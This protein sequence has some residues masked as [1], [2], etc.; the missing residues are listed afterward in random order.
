MELIV[1]GLLTISILICILSIIFCIL[2]IIKF[3]PV[4]DIPGPRG[5]DGDK[6]PEG[7]RGDKGPQGQQGPYGPSFENPNITP[8]DRT[9]ESSGPT[10][11]EYWIKGYG[12]YTELWSRAMLKWDPS[13]D[14]LPLYIICT[15]VVSDSPLLDIVEGIENYEGIVVQLLYTNDSQ[16]KRYSILENRLPRWSS[17]QIY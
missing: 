16:R 8:I 4:V 3:P 14:K 10:V 11:E 9:S 12:V 15:T 5:N 6:G 2:S 13:N 17:W 1:G 7:E